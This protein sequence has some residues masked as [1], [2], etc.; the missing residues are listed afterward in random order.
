VI[1]GFKQKHATR[2]LRRAINTAAPTDPV[3][4]SIQMSRWQP[5]YPLH[6]QVEYLD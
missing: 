5:L 1:D 3:L 6:Q 2:H 4:Y